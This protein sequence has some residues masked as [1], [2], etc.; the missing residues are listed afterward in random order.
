MRQERP[1]RRFLSVLFP[2]LLLAVA[3]AAAEDTGSP[4]DPAVIPDRIAANAVAL[5]DRALEDDLSVDIVHRQG[6]IHEHGAR[7]VSV[8][9]G[10]EIEVHGCYRIGPGLKLLGNRDMKT[11]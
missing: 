11:I 6:R 10:K 4:S 5:R 8:T 9:K 2:V 3:P 1:I 7:C